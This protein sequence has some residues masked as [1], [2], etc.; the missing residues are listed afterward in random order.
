MTESAAKNPTPPTRLARDYALHHPITRPLQWLRRGIHDTF[1][2]PA[3]SLLYGLAVVLGS[4]SIIIGVLAFDLAHFLLPCLAGLV[5]IGPALATGLYQKSELLM[6][7]HKPG[8]KQVFLIKPGASGQ[9]FFIGIILLMLT[10]LWLR[11]AF[12]LYALFFG[13]LPFGGWI[14]TLELVLTTPLGWGLIGVGSAVGGLFAAFAFAISVFSV[15]LLLNNK[16]DVFTAMGH[17]IAA[18]WH[19]KALMIAWGAIIVALSALSAFTGLLAMIVVFPVLG[20]ATWH[21]YQDCASVLRP[22]K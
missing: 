8:W 19:N 21:A 20:H 5:V 16:I 18:A 6:K 2:Q 22:A 9:I 4:W 13:L 1:T 11:T 10:V 12:L 7:G 15:P 17:S 14:G 3:M